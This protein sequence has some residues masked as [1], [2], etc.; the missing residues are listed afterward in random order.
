MEIPTEYLYPVQAAM[1]QW[2]D[3]RIIGA[4]DLENLLLFVIYAPKVL[5]QSRVTVDGWVCRQKQDQWLLT[6]K[7]RENETPLVVFITSDTP[8]GCMVR[9]W[10]LFE[11][12]R[13]KWVKDRYPW[14]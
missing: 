7:A 2:E 10:D 4:T 1:E 14:N 6:V 8:T 9:F 5:S 12:D 13:L 11:N 3:G